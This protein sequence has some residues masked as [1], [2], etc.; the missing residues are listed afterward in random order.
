MVI[1]A[2][3][4]VFLPRYW[5]AIGILALLASQAVVLSSWSDARFGTVANVLIFVAVI[6]G[7]ASQGPLSFRADY[8]R[9]V[10]KRQALL[11][12]SPALLREADLAH[13]PEPVQAYVR[14]SG[15]VGQPQVES[16]Y[17]SW[18]GRIRSG[19]EGSWMSVTAEQ[20]NFLKDPARLYFM[21]ARMGIFPAD[22]YHV[23]ADGSASM[24]VRALSVVPIVSSSGPD[25]T[26]AETVT[27]FNDLCILAPGALVDPEIQWEVIDPLTVRA[28]YTL[29]PNTIAATLNFNEAGEL[30]DFVSDDR[31]VVSSDGKTFTS[32]RWSTPIEEYQTLGGRRVSSRAVGFW[33]P[34]EGA[35]PYIELELLELQINGRP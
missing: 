25:L 11:P 33:H 21:D 35:Y 6:L 7:F 31:L 2:G 5:W 12:A 29:G 22:V 28:H 9:Q 1:S 10:E 16:I 27:I 30:V 3:A 14:L 15:A 13:L 20:H 26:R 4:V 34:A 32:Q 17:S 23:F 24:R 18:R 8:R 19:P